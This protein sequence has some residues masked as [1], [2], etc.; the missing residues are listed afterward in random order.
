MLRREADGVRWWVEREALLGRMTGPPSLV[1]A[2]VTRGD[3]AD[4]ARQAEEL[5]EAVERELPATG[6][7]ASRI[8]LNGY[9][10]DE[11]EG[12]SH[13]SGRWNPERYRRVLD[14]VARPDGSGLDLLWEVA[15][16]RRPPSYFWSANITLHC[17]THFTQ[18]GV[19][20]WTLHT[21][22]GLFRDEA[23]GPAGEAWARLLRLAGGWPQ[24]QWGAVFHDYWQFGEGLPYERYFR[25][26]IPPAD[27]AEVARGYYWANLLTEGHLAKLGGVE[28]VAGRC[29]ELGL[30]CEPVPGRT[31]AVVVRAAESV[32]T[33]GD[34]TLAALREVLRP[35]LREVRYVY[36]AGPPLRILKEPGTAFRWIP[37]AYQTPLFEND[38]QEALDRIGTGTAYRLVSG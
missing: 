37:P 16:R 5:A 2:W 34:D 20:R 19:W 35:V 15:D 26:Q 11:D 6:M 25:L 18:P 4:A 33:Y 22:D 28:T 32:A 30:G 31:E 1:M 24:T 13:D 9:W 29:A 8:T 38:P 21:S 14:R 23:L 36:Y 17:A 10:Q 3:S 12:W 7:L 27:T